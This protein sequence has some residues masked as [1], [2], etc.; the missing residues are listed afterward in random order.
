MAG[1]TPL[2]AVTDWIT[3][4]SAA[5]QAVAAVAIV[6]LTFFLA[7]FAKD[8][9]DAAEKQASIANEALGTANRQADIAN[10][11]LETAN[12]QADIAQQALREADRQVR[13]QSAGLV[14]LSE[15]IPEDDPQ[16]G[17]LTRVKLTNASYQPVL[18]VEV[19]IYGLKDDGTVFGPRGT[20]PQ[21]PI[22][23]PNVSEP[24]WVP[25]Q[26]LRQVSDSRSTQPKDPGYYS[27]KKL[28]L[29]AKWTSIMGAVGFVAYIWHANAPKYEH[30]WRLRDTKIRPWGREEEEEVV[31][32]TP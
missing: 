27:Y 29:E 7:R 19:R 24:V 26:D 28:V 25:S 12:R 14:R 15:P 21:I 31:K 5:V 32:A 10:Q 11:T 8:A 3:P 30:R 18:D 17:L 23:Q 16:R 22:L 2:A 20:S 13:R 4:V 9:T 6:A 1:V